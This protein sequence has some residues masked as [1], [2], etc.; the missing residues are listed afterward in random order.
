MKSRGKSTKLSTKTPG[1]QQDIK[2]F[3]YKFYSTLSFLF[4][5]LLFFLYIYFIYFFIDVCFV[6]QLAPAG[7]WR[8]ALDGIT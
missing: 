5:R 3:E 7:C 2:G 6:L 1:L 8:V 4:L